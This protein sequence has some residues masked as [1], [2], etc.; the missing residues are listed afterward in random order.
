MGQQR[1][2]AE[3]EAEAAAEAEAEAAH[4]RFRCCSMCLLMLFGATRR[5]AGHLHL[6]GRHQRHEEVCLCCVK[7]TPAG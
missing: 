4:C 5:M 1:Q 2:S 6:R 3:A 7:R